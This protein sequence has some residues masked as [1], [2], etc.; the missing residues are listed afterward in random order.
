M[1]AINCK[2]IC[3][4]NG[5]CRRSKL[6]IQNLSSLLVILSNVDSSHLTK[7]NALKSKGNQRMFFPG[8]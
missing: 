4:R 1:I 8:F 2:C 7:L 3:V 6:L 5:S